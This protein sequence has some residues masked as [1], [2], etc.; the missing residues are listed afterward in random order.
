[1]GD[2]NIVQLA[3][4]L[5]RP[6]LREHGSHTFFSFKVQTDST[7]QAFP[8]GASVYIGSPEDKEKAQAVIDAVEAGPQWAYVHNGLEQGNKKNDEYKFYDVSVR[9]SNLT[10]VPGMDGFCVNNSSFKGKILEMGRK[11]DHDWIILGTSYRG[12]D[13]DDPDKLGEWKDRFVR[14]GV[15]TKLWE[16]KKQ[17]DVGARIIVQGTIAEKFGDDYHHHVEAAAVTVL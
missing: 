17:P 4:K 13:K 2:F 7:K 10:L 11:E 5:G 12:R 6:D 15:P 9:L 3:G 8:V 14:I 1:M 16:G